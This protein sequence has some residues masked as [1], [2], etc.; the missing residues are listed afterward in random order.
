MRIALLIAALAVVVAVP[1]AAPLQ[2]EL[3]GTISVSFQPLA[4]G[5]TL[6]GCSLAYQAVAV[7][8]ATRSGRPV[9]LVGNISTMFF[10][11]PVLSLKVGLSDILTTGKPTFEAPWFAYLTTGSSSTAKARYNR[12]TG[13]PGFRLFVVPLFDDSVVQVVAG[14]IADK[15]V[16]IGFTQKEQGLD[17]TAPLDLTVSEVGQLEGKVVRKHSEDAVLRFRACFE[18]LLKS[19][20]PQ[21]DPAA[22]EPEP[23]SGR[24][25]WVIFQSPAYVW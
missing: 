7:D 25:P 10:D 18:S 4:S 20:L 14:M 5:G 22:A 21:T 16:T 8:H 3:I 17:V 6:K 19:R 13:E 12:E 11:N 24:R 2:P 1:S 23:A 9:T 15:K